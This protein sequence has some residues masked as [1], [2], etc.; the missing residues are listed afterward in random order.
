[1]SRVEIFD[2]TQ[3]SLGEGPLWHPTRQQFFWFDI[4]AK[5]LYTRVGTDTTHWQFDEHVSAAGWIDA[6][7]LIVASET[8]LL[9]FDIA[10][11]TSETLCA[12]EADNPLTRS[13]DGRAD[14]WG[15]FW[16]GTMDKKATKGAGGIYRY[17][18]GE[19]RQ[20]FDDWTIPNAMCFDAGKRFACIT[21]TI[22]NVVQRVPLEADTGW[23]SG[24]A[25]DWLTLGD[26]FHPD[27]AVLDAQGNFWCAQYGHGRLTCHDTNGAL[28]HDIALPAKQPT[29]PAF[30][31]ARLDELWVTS[32]AQG[33][34]DPG[35][36]DGQT[37]RIAAPVK[38]VA[39]YQVVA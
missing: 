21:D 26:R 19:L 29:C 20:L 4:N 37:F 25:Q 9:R 32:A 34:A 28:I 1:M 7:H 38:G 16:I 33:M 22:T 5:R 23:P 10:S 15:G 13:N 12:L 17:Y 6:D 3:C 14:P 8:A 36:A 31:G 30:C 2:A 39:E 35:T 18:K 27:G 11:G 24:P